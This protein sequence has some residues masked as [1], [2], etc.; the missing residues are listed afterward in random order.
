MFHLTNAIFVILQQIAAASL[1]MNSI[2]FLSAYPASVSEGYYLIRW[3]EGSVKH[4]Q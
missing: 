4:P 2:D 1:E 3:E